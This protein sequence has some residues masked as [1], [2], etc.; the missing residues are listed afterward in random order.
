MLV[1]IV[2]SALRLKTSVV[3][4]RRNITIVPNVAVILLDWTGPRVTEVFA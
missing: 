2:L 4:S 3:R 1:A